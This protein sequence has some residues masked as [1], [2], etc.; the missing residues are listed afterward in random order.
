MVMSPG[1]SVGIVKFLSVEI[2]IINVG[3]AA[4]VSS[5]VDLFDLIVVHSELL[6]VVS[7]LA[8]TYDLCEPG[9]A[10]TRILV[11]RRGSVKTGVI[12]STGAFTGITGCGTVVVLLTV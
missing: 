3:V 6:A 4:I 10:C 12:E 5:F 7:I 9:I 11:E 1:L 8:Q 2:G